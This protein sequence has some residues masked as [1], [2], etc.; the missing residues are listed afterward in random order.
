MLVVTAG[1]LGTVMLAHDDVDT[2]EGASNQFVQRGAAF[3]PT[4]GVILGYAA[5]AIEAYQDFIGN[6]KPTD[7]LNQ[8]DYKEFHT[9]FYQSAITQQ[10]NIEAQLS[11]T[12][13][14]LNDTRSIALMKGK[15]AYVEALNSGATEG[16][17]QIQ[18]YNAIE[19]YYSTK[20]RNLIA[21]WN[22]TASVFQN[23]IN[24]TG[25]GPNSGFTDK[26]FHDI[27][28]IENSGGSSARNTPATEVE[29]VT[30]KMAGVEAITDGSDN[31]TPANWAIDGHDI[32]VRP[33]PD[34][35]LSRE[36]VVDNS[37]WTSAWAD[38]ESQH[39]SAKTSMQS[40]INATY[41]SYQAG[42]LNAS[43]FVDPY[44]GAR[45]YSPETSN[46]FTLRS[47]SAMGVSP[48][49][50]LSNIG[51]MNVSADGTTYRGVLMSQGTPAGGFGINET[52]NATNI[53]GPQWVALDDGGAQELTGEFTLK[54][55]TRA[56]GTTYTEN[57]SVTYKNV[58]Y[59]TADVSELQ[60][61][62]NE[63]RELQAQINAR[64]QKLRNSGGAG[65]L[66]DFNV[67]GLGSVA[68]VVLLAGGAVVLLARN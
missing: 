47:L 48:P 10:G 53:E 9:T 38:I 65:W 37:R 58:T 64:Q 66:P 35:N 6:N 59:E 40:F 68:P 30:G 42:D 56:D 43:D 8:A 28:D 46:T 14:Y 24:Q 17:A 41:D 50:N 21:A 12:E 62:L 16:E 57:E 55:A 51:L 20:Q 26:T 3:S 2:I 31:A 34:S 15:K 52:Y 25:Q 18:A 54:S 36:L 7:K 13:N 29:L 60:T 27:T 22:M 67:G 32:Y 19:S 11:V 4:N 23:G 61:L 45:D 33:P 39:Q 63:T 1:A 49:E 44:L 5:G